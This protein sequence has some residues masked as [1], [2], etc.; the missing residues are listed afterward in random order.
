MAFMCIVETT[1][2]PGHLL[3]IIAHLG[4]E[5]ISAHLEVACHRGWGVLVSVPHSSTEQLWQTDLVNEGLG[6][7]DNGFPV[8]PIIAIFFCSQGN[9]QKDRAHPSPSHIFFRRPWLGRTWLSNLS[10]RFQRLCPS[11]SRGL[12]WEWANAEVR[13]L[14]L[15]LAMLR[16]GELLSW[17]LHILICQTSIHNSHRDYLILRKY[18]YLHYDS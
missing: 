3:C 16:W 7:E 14:M 9:P 5:R 13:C 18:R 15:P 12:V 11:P 10:P 1:T 17:P 2:E 8:W 4:R 6:P